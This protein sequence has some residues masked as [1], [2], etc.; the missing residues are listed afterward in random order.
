M[1]PHLAHTQIL[2][3]IFFG[4]AREMRFPISHGLKASPK[5]QRNNHRDVIKST[6]WQVICEKALHVEFDR[7]P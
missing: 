2:Q 3:P 5:A 1:V 7:H 6:M 4:L